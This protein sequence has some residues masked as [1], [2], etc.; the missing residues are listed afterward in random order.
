MESA[1]TPSIRPVPP[2]CSPPRGGENVARVLSLPEAA[3]P[4]HI[5]A[6]LHDGVLHVTLTKKPEA[7][8]KR[9]TVT[10]R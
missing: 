5:Q 9:I 2:P 6:E 7:Q 3:D 10:A 8:P 1:E 4:D